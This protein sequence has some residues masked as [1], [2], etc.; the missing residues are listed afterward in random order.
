MNNTKNTIR[1]TESQLHNII[2]ESVRKVLNEAIPLG[3][4]DRSN[5]VLSPKEKNGRSEMAD[6]V[7]N[8]VM[9]RLSQDRFLGNLISYLI[10]P[11]STA[12]GANFSFN[13][14]NFDNLRRDLIYYAENANENA[15][16]TLKQ[17]CQKI[18]N[19]TMFS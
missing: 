9:E 18:D 1:L 11:Y 6:K 12:I 16:Y 14:G 8:T 4:I 2:K 5:R 19:G 17:I 10:N 3:G 13:E 15:L 7:F